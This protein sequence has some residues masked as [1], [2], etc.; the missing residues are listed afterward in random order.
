ME[1]LSFI[2]NRSD[3][4]MRSYTVKKMPG[5]IK[6]F[7]DRE[8]LVSDIPAGDGKIGNCFLQ[9]REP[10]LYFNWFNVSLH[11]IT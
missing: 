11:M 8:S 5:I 3:I 4:Q 9:C 7:P 6:L 10:H 1:W 2:I